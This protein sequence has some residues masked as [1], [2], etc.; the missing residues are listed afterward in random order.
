MTS[1]T[2]LKLATIAG[3]R[4]E[5]RTIGALDSQRPVLV[6]LHE[7][8]GC[9]ALWRDFPDRLCELTNC[10]GLI[11]SRLGYGG[12]D[13][14]D[15]PRPLDYMER[16]ASDM[17][18]VILEHFNIK[19]P[20]LVGHSDG[21]S[22]SLIYAGLSD[23][24]KPEAVIVMAPH[25]FCEDISVDGIKTAK[26]AYEQRDLKEKL[27]KFHGINTEC[28]FRG[29]NDAW[30]DPAFK[31]WNIESFLP[32]VNMPLLA[33]QG[34]ED[35]YGTL[36]QIDAIEAAVSGPF[37]KLILDDCGHNPWQ[38]KAEDVLSYAAEFISDIGVRT[39]D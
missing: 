1:A 27:E 4:I 25:V 31:N 12:S 34:R 18:P 29:W 35:S 15:L 8:L 23:V 7:G 20:L 33:I 38:E 6:F 17:L 3:K 26:Q 39:A 22:I 30:L 5:Y 19:R 13:A 9:T 14:C 37:E 24:A 32:S 2:D 11:Y 16:E 36:A 21:A 28:A 10:T